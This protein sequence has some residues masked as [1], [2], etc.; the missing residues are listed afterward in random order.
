M[1]EDKIFNNKFNTGD[2]EYEVFGKISVKSDFV[3]RD[4]H[5][6]YVEGQLQEDIYDIFINSPY[7]EEFS[8]NKKVSKSEAAN[9]YYYF[10][11]RLPDNDD[12][13]AIEKFINIAEFMSIPYE[14]LYTELAPVYKEKLLRELDNKYQI[15]EKRKIKRL[16]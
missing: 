8:K 5:E 15:F 10:D 1:K 9:I 14:V 3:A 16:F 2:V 7:F 11:D 6:E 4:A 12:I 13:S